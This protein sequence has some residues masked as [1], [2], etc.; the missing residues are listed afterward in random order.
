MMLLLKLA[1]K[2]FPTIEKILQE[3]GIPDDFKYLA[4]IESALENVRSPKGAKGFWQIMPNT[5]KEYG[6]EVNSNVDERYHIEKATRVAS[7]YLKKAK[8]R[9]GSWTLAAASYNRGMY[10]TDRLL[11]KQITDN[12][13]DL[14]LNSET[15]RYVFRILAVK[16]IMSNPNR[17][18]F[19][20]D[21]EDLYQPIPVRKMG[22]DTAITNLAKFA[23]E[24]S[25][26]YKIL[27]IHNPWL[28]QNHLNN[29]SR[30]YY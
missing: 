6:L 4:V 24:H 10:C 27:K 1:N 16:E 14:L 22:L 17:Y 3:E 12:Y 13:Y 11:G 8:K 30:K 18:G 21:S 23:K 5:A 25:I 9:L 7:T 2:F 29:K 15:S 26:N 19:I 20:F 28:I